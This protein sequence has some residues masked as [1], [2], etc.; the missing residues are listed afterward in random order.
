MIPLT[1]FGRCFHAAGL[2]A[3][4]SLAVLRALA[5]IHQRA[6]SLVTIRVAAR[7]RWPLVVYPKA[8]SD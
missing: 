8:D 4:S 1:D 3:S 5:A 2:A 7:N 6:R